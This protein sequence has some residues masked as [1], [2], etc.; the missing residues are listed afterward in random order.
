MWDVIRYPIGNVSNLGWKNVGFDSPSS[1]GREQ[2][3][4][5]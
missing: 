1:G 5:W 2:C 4:I 3:G